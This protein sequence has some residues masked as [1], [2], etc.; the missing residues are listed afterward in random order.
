MTQ[1]LELIYFYFFLWLIVQSCLPPLGESSDATKKPL[2]SCIMAFLL[3][4]KYSIIIPLLIAPCFFILTT[5]HRMLLAYLQK[6]L[7]GCLRVT[8]TVLGLKT[9][10]RR[11][12]LKLKVRCLL[13]TIWFAQSQHLII[14]VCH[15]GKD[16]LLRLFSN[17][18]WPTTCTQ[19]PSGL[20]KSHPEYQVYPQSFIHNKCY[21]EEKTVKYINQHCMQS[22]GTS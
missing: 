20:W 16:W 21:Q 9:K 18:M 5:T 10:R 19:D 1:K 8:F 7:S 11:S 15:I 12:D 4:A 2:K 13:P 14:M 6:R 22:M 17:R 3:F